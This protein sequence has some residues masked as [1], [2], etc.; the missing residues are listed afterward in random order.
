MNINNKII[1][2]LFATALAANAFI[3]I[4][5]DHF[6]YKKQFAYADLYPSV[7]PAALK[8]IEKINDSSIQLNLLNPLPTARWYV[9]NAQ[10]NNAVQ[11]LAN[12]VII[13]QNGTNDYSLFSPDYNDSIKFR[14]EYIPAKENGG[15]SFIGKYKSTEAAL[16]QQ[17]VE[18][19]SYVSDAL[20]G[21]EQA[22]IT[23]ILRDSIA[24]Q[25]AVT[26]E[27]KQH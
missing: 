16:A 21:S 8:N 27:K 22:E 5:R 25:N 26:A 10:K 12:P 24:V 17:Q 3:F 4:H 9:T 14:I 7:S 18:D 15:S 19:G 1:F 23:Q 20:T 2:L 13:L 6:V 11:N